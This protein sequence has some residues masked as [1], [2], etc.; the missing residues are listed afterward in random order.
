MLWG[1]LGR[2]SD[3]TINSPSPPYGTI[4]LRYFIPTPPSHLSLSLV[5][6]IFRRNFN[7]FLSFSPFFSSFF[8]LTPHTPSIFIPSTSHPPPTLPLRSYL[9]YPTRFF[10]HHSP[11]LFPSYKT[12]V[13][14]VE[15]R[16]EEMAEI[17]RGRVKIER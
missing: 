10:Y 15:E 8:P 11:H 14:K 2:L 17:K 6:Q 7:L 9:N 13:K 16:K 1:N 3:L 12:R 5:H 4:S